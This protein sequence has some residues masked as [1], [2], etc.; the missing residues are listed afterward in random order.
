MSLADRD[1]SRQGSRQQ[2]ANWQ[3]IGT[4]A[5]TINGQQGRFL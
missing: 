5:K 3:P 1:L 4:F 2:P